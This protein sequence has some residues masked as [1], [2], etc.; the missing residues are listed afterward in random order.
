MKK[1]EMNVFEVEVTICLGCYCFGGAV[2]ETGYA[3]IELTDE[4]LKSLIVLIKESGTDDVKEMK[5][6]DKLP[7]I[8]GKLDNAYREA[9]LDAEEYH[10]LD[11]GWNDPVVF[12]PSDYVEYGEKELGYKFEYDESEF[13]DEDGKLDE[14]YLEDAKEQDFREWLDNYKDSLSRKESIEFMRR[15]IDIEVEGKPYEVRI[16]QEILDMC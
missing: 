12:N 4:E 7:E 14:D 6:K 1:G 10:W 16:P 5:L 8:Y 9:A 3:T 15:F 2:T 13:L 11:R